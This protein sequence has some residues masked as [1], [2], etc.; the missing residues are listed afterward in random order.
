MVGVGG[1]EPP[2][3]R[4]RTVYATDAPHPVSIGCCYQPLRGYIVQ[5]K[6]SK[7]LST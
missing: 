2:A 3:S 7:I 5:K 1:I 6:V 4:S